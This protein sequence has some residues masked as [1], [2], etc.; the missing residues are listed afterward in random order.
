MSLGRV[1]AYRAT[2]RKNVN[3]LEIRRPV[4]QLRIGSIDQGIDLAGGELRLQVA[5]CRHL[6]PHRGLFL[7]LRD[8]FCP[9]CVCET[10]TGEHSWTWPAGVLVFARIDP[11]RQQGERQW[12]KS[13][14]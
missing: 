10:G 11:S 4:I 6:L 9:A 14:Q 7:I 1:K 13:W 12:Q 8:R 2:A 5:L 3:R